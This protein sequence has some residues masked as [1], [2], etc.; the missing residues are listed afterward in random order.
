MAEL[1]RE[2]AEV[3]LAVGICR[4]NW[5]TV[6]DDKTLINGGAGGKFRRCDS[7]NAGRRAVAE[8]V[9]DP[10]TLQTP[11]RIA[12]AFGYAT[13]PDDAADRDALLRQSAAP[14]IRMV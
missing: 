1:M 10:E 5:R 12:L 4:I 9:S 13:F 14:R 2:N 3:E 11:A 7:Q 8:S 6:D